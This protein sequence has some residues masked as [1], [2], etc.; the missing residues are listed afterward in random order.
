M[1]LLSILLCSGYSACALPN[2]IQSPSVHRENSPTTL[3]WGD[4]DQVA[5]C[6]WNQ[7]CFSTTGIFKGPKNESEGNDMG[8]DVSGSLPSAPYDTILQ[9]QLRDVLD[10]HSGGGNTL[11]TKKSISTPLG[12][13][14]KQNVPVLQTF[15]PEICLQLTNSFP[16]ICSSIGN[17]KQRMQKLTKCTEHNRES[18][19]TDKLLVISLISLTCTVH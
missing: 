17:V 16:C 6:L 2:K 3:M 4:L 8:M 1:S 9:S 15:V 13:T 18:R 7:Y 12:C 11:F 10:P 5:Q 19:T 14:A